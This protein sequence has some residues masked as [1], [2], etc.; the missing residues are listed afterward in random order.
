MIRP[1]LARG[2]VVLCDRFVDSS[3]A[4]QGAGRTLRTDDVRKLSWFATDGLV[5]ELQGR[6]AFHDAYD[7]ATLRG[8]LGL[9]RPANRYSNV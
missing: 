5:P 8:A 1:A 2:D 7:A 3:L 6:G 9:P 4:Y